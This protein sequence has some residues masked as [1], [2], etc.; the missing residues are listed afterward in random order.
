[1]TLTT[2]S[3]DGDNKLTKLREFRKP[4]H[5]I[6]LPKRIDF[7]EM[8]GGRVFSDPKNHVANSARSN[9]KGSGPIFLRKFATFFPKAVWNFS[10]NASV[11]VW[12]RKKMVNNPFRQNWFVTWLLN[13]IFI[14]Y[15]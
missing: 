13:T 6:P 11:L 5:T 12:C 8:F 4:Y 10:E 1:M 7:S 2:R 3:P 15:V 14:L 9:G